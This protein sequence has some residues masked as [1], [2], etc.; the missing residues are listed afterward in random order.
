MRQEDIN[1]T[2]VTNTQLTGLTE[3]LSHLGLR[4]IDELGFLVE[5]C[6]SAS[7]ISACNP[8]TSS[9]NTSFGPKFSMYRMKI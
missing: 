8:P 2:R 6:R 4:T 1:F 5:V 7:I 3:L 9:F